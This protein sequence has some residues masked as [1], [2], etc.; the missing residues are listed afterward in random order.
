MAM[1]CP[2]C[3]NLM[4][5]YERNGVQVDQCTECKGIFLDRG[6]LERLIA[7]E[8]TWNQ[9]TDPAYE[10][11]RRDDHDDYYQDEHGRFR[12]PHSRKRRRRSFL[13]ELFDD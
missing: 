3:T 6:E 9:P 10:Q 1:L 13:E 12:Q 5:C 4:T 8:G 2:K 7:A 11:P